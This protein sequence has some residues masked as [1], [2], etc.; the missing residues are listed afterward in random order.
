MNPSHEL[1]CTLVLCGDLILTLGPV[2]LHLVGV[3]V[4]V[5]ARGV[6]TCKGGTLT[7][8]VLDLYNYYQCIFS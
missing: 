1:V 4:C 3:C 7:L 5:C 6:A 8:H 2:I